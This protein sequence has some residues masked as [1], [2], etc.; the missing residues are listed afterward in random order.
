M[1]SHTTNV[2]IALIIMKINLKIKKE[3][4][5]SNHLKEIDKIVISINTT[6]I[7]IMVANRATTSSFR[8]GTTSLII[9]EIS[10]T[11]TTTTTLVCR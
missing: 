11:I 8:I 9:T 7:I 4:I 5:G 1:S 10:T 6:N 3:G 2:N